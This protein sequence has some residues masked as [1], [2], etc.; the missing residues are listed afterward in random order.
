MSLRK[1]FKNLSVSQKN[2]RLLKAYKCLHNRQISDNNVEEDDNKVMCLSEIVHI[3]PNN[4]NVDENID[5]SNSDISS[6]EENYCIE[7]DDELIINDIIDNNMNVINRSDFNFK[8]QLKQWICDY[9]IT[10]R[11]TEALLKLLK[12]IKDVNELEDLPLDPRTLLNTPKHTVTREVSPG[13]YFH[14][15]LE[16]ALIDILKTVHLN[17]VPCDR[18]SHVRPRT[19]KAK[20]RSRD[21]LPAQPGHRDC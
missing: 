7:N 2:R 12:N 1:N 9:N 19:R 11:A 3:V 15:G 18:Q 14:Y 6:D 5:F 4:E 16:N 17:T 13:K 10:Y 8:E 20:Q 21:R